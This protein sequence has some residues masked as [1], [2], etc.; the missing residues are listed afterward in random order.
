M[1][2][3]MKDPQWR[4]MSYLMIPF[5]IGHVWK[6]CF[7]HARL[8]AI[9]VNYLAFLFYFFLVLILE[10]LTLYKYMTH[11]RGSYYIFLIG[12]HR[13]FNNFSFFAGNCIVTVKKKKS[14]FLGSFLSDHPLRG[15]RVPIGFSTQTTSWGS[16]TG[17]ILRKICF[18]VKVSQVIFQNY[19][20]TD[21]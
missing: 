4:K 13:M 9:K 7:R 12:L 18:S 14:A 17:E 6:Y 16:C 5:T 1:S 10:N 11:T 21:F 3:G 19:I 20:N 15:V 8:N 2:V